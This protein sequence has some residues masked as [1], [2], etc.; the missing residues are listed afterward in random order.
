[1]DNSTPGMSEKLVEYLDGGLSGG[2]KQ[3][4]EKQLAADAVLQQEYQNLL[5]T[6]AA[7][8]YH[9]LQQQVAG[10]H[11]QVMQKALSPVKPIASLKRKVKYSIAIA[12]SILLLAGTYLVY[13]FY[14]L[15]P[16]KIFDSNYRAYELSTP[17]DNNQPETPVEKAYRERDYAAL[18]RSHDAGKD[19]TPGGEF[20]CGMA[21]LELKA[22]DKAISYF[23]KVISANLKASPKVLNDEAEYYLSLAYIRNEDY[24]YALEL[25][26]KI[27][28]DPGHTYR[29]KVTNK[30][31]RQVRMLKWR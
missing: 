21:A 8:K 5:A 9:G 14:T 27:K 31:I 1:M 16:D 24:D 19:K 10:I 12:A 2:D 6:R 23:N 25:L 11:R 17:R 30:L 15:S 13:N 7:I 26:R 3:E 29:E 20:L 28:E 22:N 18:I 4:L